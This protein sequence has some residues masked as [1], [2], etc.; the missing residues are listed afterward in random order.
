MPR[1]R[2]PGVQICSSHA[3]APRP[4]NSAGP[5]YRC[6]HVTPPPPPSPVPS[7]LVASAPHH[8]VC[9]AFPNSRHQSSPTPRSKTRD[10]SHSP[11]RMPE[12]RDVMHPQ[13]LVLRH[14]EHP[15][16]GRHGWNWAPQ[17]PQTP[18]NGCMPS[19]RP[20]CVKNVMK[21]QPPLRIRRPPQNSPHGCSSPVS[22]CHCC[23]GPDQHQQLG[24]PQRVT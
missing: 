13:C 3:D 4:H 22:P 10:S 11:C 23:R 5:G 8:P 7:L 6:P 9:P 17:H 1:P 12:L 24:R 16:S 15:L 18:E 19:S 20:V 14:S 21:V 2:A